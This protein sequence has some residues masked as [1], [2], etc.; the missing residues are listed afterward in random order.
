MAQNERIPADF[1]QAMFRIAAIAFLTAA[2]VNVGSSFVGAPH[3][4]F[5]GIWIVGILS[6]VGAVVSW[7]FP[8]HRLPVERFLVV[9]VVP[10]LVLLGFMLMYTGGIHS[11]ILPIFIAPAVFMAAAYGFRTGAAIALLTAATAT[12]PLF[13]NGWDNFYARTLVVLAV[14]T[15]LC[16]YIP[17][18]VRRALLNE[19]EGRRRQQEESYVATIGALAAAL[20]AKD[21]YTEEHSRET[22]ELAVNVGK[23]LGL[24]AEQLRLLEYGALLHD[25]GKIGI[26]GYILQKPGQLTPE[27]FAIM[28][29]HPVIGERI[30]ASVPF[31]APLGPIVRA[32][33]ERWNG[34][35]YPDGLKGEE[36]P[37]EARIIHACDSFHAMASDRSYRKALPLEEIVAEFRKETSQ[38]F[39][40]RVVDVMLELIEHDP[41]HITAA[42]D[43]SG[44]PTPEAALSGPRGWAQHMQTVETLGQQLARATSIE[45]ICN[46]IGETITALL[47]HDQ[48]RVL[49][50]NEDHSRLQ[51]VYLR[52]TDREEY[53][54]VTAGNAAVEMGEGIAGWVAESRRGVVLGDTEHH[55]KAA[56]VQ[57][58]E[59]IDES[60]LAVPVMFEDEILA[61]IV[62][63]KLG[64]NQYSLDQLRLLTILANQAAVSMANARL[65]DRLA[66]AATVDALTGLMNRAAFEDAVNKRML[67]PQSWGTLLMLDVDNL[68]ETNA[69]YGHRAGDAVLKRIARAIRTSIRG[70]DLASRWIGDDFAILAPGIDASQ[71]GVLAGRIETALQSDRISIRWGT[72]EYHG[73]ALT[74]QDLLT[75][76]LKSMPGR[77]DDLAAQA[78]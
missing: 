52:G 70:D 48:C 78:S 12:L 13:I 9:I 24:P 18:R 57:G 59:V 65:I 7:F 77:R 10:G 42:A 8:W 60:M 64:L 1:H 35:G 53:R 41:P 17:A 15:M 5:A 26:P 43:A 58:T 36:I 39:D 49:L 38:Q 44:Q 22:A 73:D 67:R 66:S 55:P 47:P 50:M 54:E 27:E 71:A 63:L 4:D 74:A 61:V 72:A 45:D 56:H 33:H 29:E 30:L 51:V 20:D 19:Y 37:I 6:C 68:R 16:A 69:A 21:R 32:E 11:H 46:R 23:R 40:P 62:V 2:T 28:R 14:A 75:A 3:L 34:T 76:A 31:L 25:I